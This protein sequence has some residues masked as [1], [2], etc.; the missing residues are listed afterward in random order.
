M[1]VAAKYSK[2]FRLIIIVNYQNINNFLRKFVVLCVK[3]IDTNV[4]EI[5][6]DSAQILSIT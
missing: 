2:N 6:G 5:L 4:K 1:A 3:N